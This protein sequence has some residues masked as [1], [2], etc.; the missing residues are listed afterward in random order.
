[1]NLMETIQVGKVC[2]T[3]PDE[4]TNFVKNFLGP[5]LEKDGK[6][7][8]VILGYDQNRADLK[9]WVD[10]MY[11]NEESSKYFDGTAVHWYDSTI[12]ILS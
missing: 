3:T 11:E 8:L 12:R 2:I 10:S 7:D 4:M 6:G 9:N 1:M 5:H